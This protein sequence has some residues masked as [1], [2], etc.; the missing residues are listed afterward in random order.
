MFPMRIPA[1]F[2]VV[3]L[4]S[5]AFVGGQTNQPVPT[6][7]EIQA[8]YTAGKF[9]DVIKKATRVLGARQ[10]DSTKAQGTGL[11]AAPGGTSTAGKGSDR[12]AI[13]AL[14]GEAHLHLKQ[15]PQ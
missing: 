15:N 13:E 11:G 3:L 14:K 12:G 5:A 1:C 9:Q 8:D 4:L 10:S 6:L 7:A 2:I